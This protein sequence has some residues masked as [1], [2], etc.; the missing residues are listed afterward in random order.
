MDQVEASQVGSNET[1]AT[2]PSENAQISNASNDAEMSE[3]VSV[4]PSPVH[5]TSQEDD[6]EGNKVNNNRSDEGAVE[7]EEGEEEE[8]DLVNEGEI[9]ELILSNGRKV[10]AVVRQVNGRKYTVE[11]QD[12]ELIPPTLEQIEFARIPKQQ[13]VHISDI[14][15]DYRRHV[16]DILF[17]T[18]QHRNVSVATLK[19]YEEAMFRYC[20]S[21]GEQVC[22]KYYHLKRK[23]QEWAVGFSD[24]I[25]V[26]H[27][28]RGQPKQP[29]LDP[30]FY[31]T[32]T[33][34]D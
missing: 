16:K 2:V 4:P 29:R 7:E 33:V 9:V 23:C 17:K 26:I 3:A 18:F 21:G 25:R 20:A 6:D 22:K 27:G 28:Q 10:S 32:E 31:W 15:N 1:T 30:V 14:N 12:V 5:E 8:A 19:I 13:Y 11:Q 24:R 34:D